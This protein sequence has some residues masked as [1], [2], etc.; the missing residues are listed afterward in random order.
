M[1][2]IKFKNYKKAIIIFISLSFIF[3]VIYISSDKAFPTKDFDKPF[4]EMIIGYME[5]KYGAHNF[6][7]KKY[8]KDYEYSGILD[9][10]S[11][12]LVGYYVTVT[13]DV[14]PETT[15]FV[16]GTELSEMKIS[17]NFM[18]DYYAIQDGLDPSSDDYIFDKYRNW[19][20]IE[21]EAVK[22]EIAKKKSEEL[23]QYLYNMSAD[24]KEVDLKNDDIDMLITIPSKLGYIPTRDELKQFVE[25]RH[26]SIKVNITEDKQEGFIS[27]LK[28]YLD[29]YYHSEKRIDTSFYYNKSNSILDVYVDIDEL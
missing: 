22:D 6:K 9:F 4:K 20:K 19:K 7:V 18:W 16:D 11:R 3:L 13:S 23:T 28:S 10:S 14:V 1:S 21:K 15:I 25:V 12:K 26:V 8:D 29:E 24:I 17:D 27:E 5:D 2:E